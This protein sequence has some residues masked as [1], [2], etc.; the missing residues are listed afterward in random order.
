VEFRAEFFNIINH[1]NFAQPAGRTVFAGT[2]TDGPNC[3]IAGCPAGTE[4]PLNAVGEILS[5]ASG[6]T[7]TQASGNS[8]QIQFGLKIVF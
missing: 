6:T 3:P 5:T 4:N 8:R 1:P 7:A 2:V